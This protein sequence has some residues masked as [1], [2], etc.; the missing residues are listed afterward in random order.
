M[1][2]IKSSRTIRLLL[3]IRKRVKTKTILSSRGQVTR[4]IENQDKRNS[5]KERLIRETDTDLTPNL[6][7]ERETNSTNSQQKKTYPSIFRFSVKF[8]TSKL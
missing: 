2:P 1:I 6:L 7:Y 8:R 3:F 4:N 5:K